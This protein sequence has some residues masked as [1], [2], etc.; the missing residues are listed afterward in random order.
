[1]LSGSVPGWSTTTFDPLRTS[2]RQWQEKG[3]LV[4][5]TYGAPLIDLV[6][7]PL[8]LLKI[9]ADELR[10]LGL[11]R[12][13]DLPR[14]IQL[15]VVTDGPRAIQVRDRDGSVSTLTPPPIREVS[16]TGSGD[17]LLACLLEAMLVRKL[18]LLEALAFA[19]PCAAANAAHER[20]AEFP[21]PAGFLTGRQSE[22]KS[23]PPE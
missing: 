15:V 2:L 3:T 10:S 19:I 7:L 14:A 18:P 12:V 16:P 23:S 11:N 17:V 6:G 8:T 1:V 21:L 5:D 13:E 9:N 20:I 4:V 22:G